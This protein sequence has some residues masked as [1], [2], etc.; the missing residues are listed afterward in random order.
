MH[1]LLKALQTTLRF[2]QEMSARFEVR[3]MRQDLLEMSESSPRE[4]ANRKQLKA[5]TCVWIITYGL[6]IWLLL[7]TFGILFQ[8][9]IG[10]CIRKLVLMFSNPITLYNITSTAYNQHTDIYS[11]YLS[12]L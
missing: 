12:N 5:G 7:Y 1:A 10:G 6:E 11:L 8:E 2:E 9:F 4:T 3:D